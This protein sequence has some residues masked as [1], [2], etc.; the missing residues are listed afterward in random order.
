MN[1]PMKQRGRIEWIDRAACRG[2]DPER[3]DV[4]HE[5]GNAIRRSQF[6]RVLEFLVPAAA[7]CARC[8]V[9]RECARDALECNDVS[10]IR[11]GVAIPPQAQAVTRIRHNTRRVLTLVASGSPP[12]VVWR[13]LPELYPNRYGVK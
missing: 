8:S 7:P 5:I 3:F 9:A 2:L 4:P 12:P 10:V 13:S 11:G 1:S 6:D